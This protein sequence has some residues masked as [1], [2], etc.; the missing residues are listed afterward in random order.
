MLEIRGLQ[1]TLPSLFISDFIPGLVERM[2][3]EI[4]SIHTD[5]ASEAFHF[6]CLSQALDFL[7]LLILGLQFRLIVHCPL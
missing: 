1:R 3:Q 7:D 4:F 5:L 2:P 6:V